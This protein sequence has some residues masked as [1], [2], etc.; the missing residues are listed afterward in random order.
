[1]DQYGNAQSGVSVLVKTAAG[2]TATIYSD[3]G[4]TPKANPITTAADGSFDFYAANG[5]YKLTV[6]GSDETNIHLFD[7]NEDEIVITDAAYGAKCDGSTDDSAAVTAA[8]AAI[9]TGTVIF[10]NGTYNYTYAAPGYGVVWDFRNAVTRAQLG[11]TSSAVKFR[12]ARF[13]RVNGPHATER[14]EGQHL[15][16]MAKGGGGYGGLGSTYGLGVHVEKENW[17][18]AASVSDGEV[19]GIYS[20]VYNGGA[21]AGGTMPGY[22]G[23]ASYL[24]D[25]SILNDSGSIQVFEGNSFVYDRTTPS[26]KLYDLNIQLASNNTRDDLFYGA[27]LNCRVGTANAAIRTASSSGATWSRILEHYENGVNTFYM[28]VQG[29]QRWR[30]NGTNMSVEQNSTTHALEVKNNAG[31]AIATVGQTGFSATMTGGTI[32]GTTIGSTT[33]AGAA[34]LRISNAS[35]ATTTTKTISGVSVLSNHW[36]YGSTHWNGSVT[37]GTT[38]LDSQITPN[39][40]IFTDGVDAATATEPVSGMLVLHACN[41]PSLTTGAQV[42]RNALQARMSV[43]TQYGDTGYTAFVAQ[44]SIGYATANQGGPGG[45]P[46]GATSETAYYRGELFGGNDNVWLASGATY[47]H[48]VI[49]REIEAHIKSGASAYAR[50]NLL[51]IDKVNG[52]QADG[53][54]V[55]LAMLSGNEG[56]TAPGFKTGISFGLSWGEFPIETG[57]TLIAI[58]ARDYPTPATPNTVAYGINF[59]EGV[60]STA[61]FASPGFTVDPDGD[62]TTKT[63]NATGSANVLTMAGSS[64]GNSVTI[65]AT[66]SDSNVTVGIIPKGSGTA[67]LMDSS[68]LTQFRSGTTGASGNTFLQVSRQNGYGYLVAENGVTDGSIRIS[69]KAAGT[70]DLYVSSGSTKVASAS[71]SGFHVTTGTVGYATG[72]GGTVTQ[73]TDKATGVTLNKAVGAITMNGAA[74]AADTTVSFVLTNSVIA[75]G[76]LIVVNHTGT[77]TFGAYTVNARSASGSATIDVRNVTAGSLSEAI[78]LSFAVIKGV[79]A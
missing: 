66:G 34:F 65:T 19:N 28:D 13:T 32:D 77:G 60:F 46:G 24:A 36:L 59:T 52:T 39:A 26:T 8:S 27:I 1:M 10:P 51:L 3:D 15:R 71:S 48:S 64:T 50:I 69:S 54:D 44:Q 33:P 9:S 40:I 23:G 49:G 45:W 18:T 2:A 73:A 55:M 70:V 37:G 67:S 35:S 68:G 31:T 29:K 63:V 47:W 5:H 79:T 56:G 42:T 78:V 17:S 30:V 72:A 57:G 53:D 7:R 76:D 22:S 62:V 75:A 38:G 61:A 6:A 4:V 11:G 43:T 74:L 41:A 20:A 21:A 58:K 16:V 25:A 14:W 12:T